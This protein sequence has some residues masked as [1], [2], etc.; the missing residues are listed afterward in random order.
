[1]MITGAGLILPDVILFAILHFTMPD[2]VP[3]DYT[4]N[5]SGIGGGVIAVLNFFPD[6]ACSTEAARQP[7]M[8]DKGDEASK[9]AIRS[10]PPL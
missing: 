1:M 7:Q 8:R 9:P 5:F 6:G 2:K 4:C 10:K 3:F